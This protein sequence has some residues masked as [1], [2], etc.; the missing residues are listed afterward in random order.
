MRR[1]G[2][3]LNY[4]AVISQ[5]HP[6][7]AFHCKEQNR[8]YYLPNYEVLNDL[9]KKHKSTL[10]S[11]SRFVNNLITFCKAVGADYVISLC[12][13]APKTFDVETLRNAFKRFIKALEN[14]LFYRA[15]LKGANNIYI[16]GTE[17]L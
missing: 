2:Y 9:L 8:T 5:T 13:T 15:K 4:E 17:T 14:E 12:L 3:E 7:V 11:T 16:W 1:L 10:N 6:I